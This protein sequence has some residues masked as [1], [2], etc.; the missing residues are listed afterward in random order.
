MLIIEIQIQGV[1]KVACQKF[2]H[3]SVLF[4]LTSST[5]FFKVE[6]KIWSFDLSERTSILLYKMIT[7]SLKYKNPAVF[8]KV[9][10]AL[11]SD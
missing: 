10:V 11:E 4:Y 6:M 3:I 1:P 5:I 9:R 2:G 7:S 8:F